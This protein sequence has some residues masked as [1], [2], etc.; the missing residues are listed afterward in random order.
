[1]KICSV[2]TVCM[3]AQSCRKLSHYV[4]SRGVFQSAWS[5][6]EPQRLQ[7]S[8]YVLCFQPSIQ[9]LG[10]QTWDNE[11]KFKHIP[12][13]SLHSSQLDFLIFVVDKIEQQKEKRH[14]CDTLPL[15]I[16]NI[17]LESNKTEV[18]Y[19]R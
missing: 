3:F 19:I 7:Q 12:N 14:I 13:R 17:H 9:K 10:Y 6:K 15:N 5:Q 4:L 2:P 8:F 16:K 18:S 11:E 1:M